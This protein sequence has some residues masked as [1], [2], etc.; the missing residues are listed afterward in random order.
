MKWVVFGVKNN[1]ALRSRVADI[2]NA[3][4]NT[5]DFIDND[6]APS[7]QAN[8]DSIKSLE[9]SI[10]D[11]ESTLSCSGSAELDV[12]GCPFG[13]TYYHGDC[14]ASDEKAARNWI[15]EFNEGYQVHVHDYTTHYFAYETNITDHNLE[16]AN[17]ASGEFIRFKFEGN[18]LSSEHGLI[19]GLTKPHFKYFICFIHRY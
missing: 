2:E 4:I 17:K 13:Y 3:L 18:I 8:T 7:V 5:N 19:K 15:D 12:C 6:I 14:V 1:L 10:D 9:S 16:E 11:I